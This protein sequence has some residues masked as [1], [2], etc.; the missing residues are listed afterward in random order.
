MENL[1]IT[2]H[3]IAVR[4]VP[5]ASGGEKVDCSVITEIRIK[6][7]AEAAQHFAGHSNLDTQ[8]FYD[9]SAELIA[10]KIARQM[11]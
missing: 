3:R 1:L 7:G 9:H 5:R 11:G 4:I 2:S 10:E 6:Y 8:K